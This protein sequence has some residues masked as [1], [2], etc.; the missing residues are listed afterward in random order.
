MGLACASRLKGSVLELGGK[1]AMIVCADAN[2]P[3]AISGCLWGGFA[4]AGQTCAGIERVYTFADLQSW[5]NGAAEAL[6]G[7]GPVV[8][9][10]KVEGRLGQK[11]PKPPRPMAEQIARLR[12]ALG[13]TAG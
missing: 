4:N 11:T 7:L 9:W 10:L 6:A 1:D 12:Q 3:N 8:I 13:V 2:L 5:T